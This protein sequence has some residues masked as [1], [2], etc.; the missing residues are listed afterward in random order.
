M[1]LGGPIRTCT[2]FAVDFNRHHKIK[3]HTNEKC[4]KCTDAKNFPNL[5]QG[6]I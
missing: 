3:V 5:L 6:T 1:L 4:E 2:A